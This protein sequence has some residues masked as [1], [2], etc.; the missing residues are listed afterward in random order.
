MEQWRQG[1]LFL[2]WSLL[3]SKAYA[4]TNAWISAPIILSQLWN[5]FHSAEIV[6]PAVEDTLK[7]LQVDC[8]DLLIF[9]K[10]TAFQVHIHLI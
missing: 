10:L 3:Q 8:V 4:T 6:Q 1:L 5:T 2:L 9:V 7:T